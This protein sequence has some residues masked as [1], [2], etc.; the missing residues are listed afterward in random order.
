MYEEV[1]R[2]E[3][4]IT[5]VINIS[6]PGIILYNENTYFEH[7]YVT[8]KKSN[9]MIDKTVPM[10]VTTSAAGHVTLPG[11]RSYA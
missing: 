11:L 2:I 1:W 4:Y 6:L 7:K 8:R 3:I 10:N 9:E 5:M